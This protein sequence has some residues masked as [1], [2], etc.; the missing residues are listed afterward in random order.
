V[1]LA[2]ERQHVVL[3][4]AVEVDVADD[5]HLVILDGEEG[6]VDQP[7]EINRISACEEAKRLFDATRGFAQ[8]VTPWIFSKL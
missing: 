1:A 7:V 3:A 2:E 5:H 8:A 6:V 4:Q